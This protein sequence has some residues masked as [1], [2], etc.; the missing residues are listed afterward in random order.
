MFDMHYDLLTLAYI[1]YK[2]NDYSELE[3]WVKNY[4]QSNVRGVIANL[5]F[6]GP[7]EMD[8]EYAKGYYNKDVS[9]L[10]M[11]KI[12][13]KIL[14][15]YLPNDT[16]ILTSI[17]GCDYIK[18]LNELEE[19]KKAGLNCII[20]VWN[21]KSRF[22]SGNRTE[23]GLTDEGIALIRKAIE[24]NLGIDLSHANE[25][26]FY[27][28][29]SVINE[30]RKMGINP[31]VYASHSNSRSLCDNPRNLT[32]DQIKALV[33]AGG[34]IGLFGN[35]NFV[36]KDSLDV[37]MSLIGTDKYEVYKKYLQRIYVNHILYV[38]SLTGGI[39]NICVSTDDMN[40]SGGYARYKHTSNFDYSNINDQ[41]RENLSSVLTPEEID[42]ITFENS[43]TIYDRLKYKNISIIHDTK[44]SFVSNEL[45]NFIN[46]G[47]DPEQ[48][49]KLE[50]ELTNSS[51]YKDFSLKEIVDSFVSEIEEATR[52]LL[53][54]K[55]HDLKYVPGIS[56]CIF[57][58]SYDNKNEIKIKLIGGHATRSED[59]IEINSDTLFDVASVTKLFTLVL[60]FK[61]EE[62]GYINLNDKIKDVNSNYS[63]LDDFT[64]ND[65]IKISGEI[66]TQSYV[67]K[68]PTKEEAWNAMRTIYV[69]SNDK[70]TNR[71][72]DLGA[73]VMSNTL[74]KIMS[75]KLGYNITFDQ[76]MDKFIFKPFGIDKACFNPITN[77][78]AGN[79]N[80]ENKVHDP[81][82]QI[83]GGAVGSAG[84]FINSDDL[85]S[86]SRELY[87]CKY[88]NY[89]K[90]KN[91]VS[92]Q[93]LNRMGEI[94]YPNG[95]QPCKGNLGI[96]VKGDPN[97]TWTPKILSTNSFSHEGWTGAVAVFDPNNLIHVNSLISAISPDDDIAPE[98]RKNDKV[99]G[100][101]EIMKSY[102]NN[103]TFSAM[104]MLIAKKYYDR[105]TKKAQNIDETIKIK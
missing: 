105:Y 81:K 1:C 71:Y 80:N 68:S 17:E 58:P 11:F 87:V 45:I 36:L 88:V 52:E 2:R 16:L 31:V 28:I 21:N 6:M 25:K 33:N 44:H 50:S 66:A 93:N 3:S 104:K 40:F 39:E 91:L 5:C 69:K 32:D 51:F 41:L 65:L 22:G 26:T 90:F 23:S 63:G 92:K 103:L 98:Y 14:N 15:K 82:S 34:K 46:T 97:L 9:V 8:N 47:S 86:F 57:L 99:V 67:A 101:K 13:M 19:L 64:F 55:N 77:N 48:V 102:V 29:L 84:L 27:G 20:P 70:S 89:N 79:G 73:I 96:F 7:D 37:K 38:K 56:S 94:T 76:I 83:L 59:S 60:L 61:L 43:K 54:K 35:C 42:K 62:L 12:S 74:E 49:L 75:E 24:L 78:I 18:D 10:E 4:N 30:Y 72:T 95:N 53:A 100:T 85:V